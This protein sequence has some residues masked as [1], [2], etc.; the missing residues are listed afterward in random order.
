MTVVLDKAIALDRT[1]LSKSLMSN[2]CER[3]GY[4]SE[5]VRDRDGKRLRFAMP[6][7]V[8]FGSAVDTAHLELTY[9]ASVGK[10]P[11]LDWAVAAGMKRA[12][13]MTCS[14]LVDWPVF[15]LQL[16]NAMTLFLS[17]P[18]G[19][20]RIPLDGIRF[21]GANG[22]SLKADDVIGTPDYLLGDGSVLDV[23]TSARTYR[24]DAF[25][26]KAEMPVYAFLA[27]GEFGILPPLLIYQ[28]YVRVARP[29]WDWLEQPGLTALV[30]IGK[31]HAARWRALLAQPVE[32]T[33]FDPGM[34]H[35]CGFRDAIADVGHEGC[36]VGQSVPRDEVEGAA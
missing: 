3:K 17:Q 34:C 24:P 22:I 32:A 29:H 30:E 12:G 20:A 25:W 6:E 2:P 14:E 28:I 5:H 9:A 7:K 4:Y 18:D 23:K 26:R 36:A 13:P 8:L 35:D 10:E 1:G 27:T 31:S 33:A 11:D 16:R 21:Q 15:E 19:L